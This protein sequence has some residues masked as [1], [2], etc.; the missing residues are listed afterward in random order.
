[1]TELPATPPWLPTAGVTVQAMPKPPPKKPTT[2]TQ[3][4]ICSK[5][6]IAASPNGNADDHFSRLE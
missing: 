4:K 2:A 6:F 1:V 5:R 3:N